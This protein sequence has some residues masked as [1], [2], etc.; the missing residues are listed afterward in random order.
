MKK[1]LLVLFA[2]SLF[3]VKAQLNYRDGLVCAVVILSGAGL[4]NSRANWTK[5][6]NSVKDKL[7][8]YGKLVPAAF[9]SVGV[10]YI[11]LACS[12]KS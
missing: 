11:A 1:L 8:Y 6:R 3:D 4:E 9:M 5:K 2:L 12:T 10:M 7:W